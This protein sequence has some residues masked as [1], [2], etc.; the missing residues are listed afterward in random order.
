M[1]NYKQFI[2]CIYL[3]HGKAVK[4]LRDDTV[5]CEDPVS[6]SSQYSGSAADAILVFDL[7]DGDAEHDEA[8]EKIREICA[9]V[10]IPVIGCGNIRRMEDVKKLIYAG[11][12]M[13]AL[14]Y[15]KQSNIDLTK[16][17]SEKFGK[18]RIA[19]CCTAADA[20]EENKELI[21]GYVQEMILLE[22]SAI[23]SVLSFSGVSIIIHIPDISLD[24]MIE[25]LGQNAI[26][27]ITGNAINENIK[28]LTDMKKFCA[29]NNIPVDLRAAAYS[30]GDLKKNSDGMVPVVVQEDATGEVLMVAYMNEEAYNTT[31]RTGRMTYWSRSR[32]ELWVKGETSGHFQYVRSITAD[33]DLDTL[34]A[35]VD[36]VGA[37]CHTGH[38]SCFFNT[39]LVLGEK[40]NNPETVLENVL[41]VVND[42]KE[43][44]KEGS[45]T[46][47]LF[48]KGIDK[49]LKKVGEEASE[50]IIASKNP[51][52]TEVVYEMSDFLYHMMVL[53]AERGITWRDITDELARREQK[54]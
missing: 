17:V 11:C 46:N 43:H 9:S 8:I 1:S 13:A 35:R 23:R 4:S 48:D 21:E 3:H 53:M 12:S 16:E 30:W 25:L 20:I 38:H 52:K 34:L 2:P 7:S 40:Q 26:S 51:E 5:I 15:S 27:G 28:N 37:A 41:T 49:I 31:V 22:E 39:D 33:C 18:E 42:R 47:Y 36:Q 6:L 54:K 29:E 10:R 50:I 45:Y 19:A 32:G 44:P 24:K 14:N